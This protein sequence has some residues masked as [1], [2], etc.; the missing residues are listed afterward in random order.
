MLHRPVATSR[1]SIVY[2]SN[3]VDL[4][5]KSDHERILFG[6]IVE[7]ISRHKAGNIGS[8]SGALDRLREDR[9][10]DDAPTAAD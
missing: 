8:I 9:E 1:D 2:N 4:S 10:E 3:C 5:E 6:S 7:R